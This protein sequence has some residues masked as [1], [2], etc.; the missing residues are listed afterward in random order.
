MRKN[1]EKQKKKLLRIK[2]I[3][4]RNF[5]KEQQKVNSKFVRSVNKQLYSTTTTTATTTSADTVYTRKYHT[6]TRHFF[7]SPNR[8][9]VW[10]L[11]CI[12]LTIHHITYIHTYVCMGLAV[13]DP[14]L[15]HGWRPPNN[16]IK[17]PQR[18]PMKL[19]CK[20]IIIS[21]VTLTCFLLIE[22]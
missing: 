19:R 4:K 12:R 2:W 3:F 22:N 6:L 14:L 13:V 20:R 18:H 21:C 5:N 15:V 17:S 11:L 10:T 9:F 16:S 1:Q 7:T 8:Q